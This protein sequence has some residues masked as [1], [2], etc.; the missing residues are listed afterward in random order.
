MT[1]EPHVPPSLVSRRTVART[2]A[3]AAPAIV[4][5]VGSP[6]FAVSPG[7]SAMIVLDRESYDLLA[8]QSLTIT[9]VVVPPDGKTLPAD[10]QLSATVT[11]G[12][13]V[14]AQPKLNGLAFSLTVKA[15][16]ATTDGVLTVSSPTQP[17]YTPGSASLS[18][19][20]VGSVERGY[21]LLPLANTWREISVSGSDTRWF[22]HTA[23]IVALTAVGPTRPL[24]DLRF[25][26]DDGVKLTNNFGNVPYGAIMKSGGFKSGWGTV[27]I[28]M[29]VS[30][31]SIVTNGAPGNPY[32]GVGLNIGTRILTG[33]TNS[34]Y[35][36][37]SFAGATAGII[38]NIDPGENP[39]IANNKTYAFMPSNFPK[40]SVVQFE[41]VFAVHMPSG[42]A[43]RIG[44]VSPT[45]RY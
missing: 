34:I 4:M 42:Q 27:R 35:A 44:F 7:V 6:A 39:I 33:P 37:H 22:T 31:V 1:P 36:Q 20:P 5:S 21:R 38:P 30:V 32:Q 19:L 11:A 14:V 40:G 12:F 28:G 23:G 8:G 18:S 15:P 43:A 10:F 26:T 13:T 17:L 29:D 41:V 3:W 25:S 45:Y 24:L 16:I 9:G 2:A